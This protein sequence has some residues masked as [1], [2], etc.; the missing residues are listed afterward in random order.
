MGPG[1]CV[2]FR[3]VGV[4]MGGWGGGKRHMKYSSCPGGCVGVRAVGVITGVGGWGK[5]Y[6]KYL[7][8]V[9]GKVCWGQGD[10]GGVGG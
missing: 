3:A 2:G 9:A 6:M 1:G 8:V 10:K 7:L 4:I 5:R